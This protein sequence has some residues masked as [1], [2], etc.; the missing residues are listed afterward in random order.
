MMSSAVQTIS[1]MPSSCDGLA[2]ALRQCFSEQYILSTEWQYRRMAIFHACVC[3]L[4]H[5]QN[6]SVSVVVFTAIS[7][8]VTLLPLGPEG[9]TGLTVLA[10]F[11]QCSVV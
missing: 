10:Q 3:N 4:S 7:R 11:H 8:K 1:H 5:C 6:K 9:Y 2:W